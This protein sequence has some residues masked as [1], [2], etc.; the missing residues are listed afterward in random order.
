MNLKRRF[1]KGGDHL[2]LTWKVFK[3][4]YHHVGRRRKWTSLDSVNDGEEYED[5][6]EILARYVHPIATYSRECINYS[7]FLSINNGV[8]TSLSLYSLVDQKKWGEEK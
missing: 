2:T 8:I 4:I 7:N 5:L 1:E 3:D 6:D